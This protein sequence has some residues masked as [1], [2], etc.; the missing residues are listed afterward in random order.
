MNQNTFATEIY[1]AVDSKDIDGILS[2]LTH[3]AHFRFANIPGAKGKDN[4]RD[5]LSA[6]YPT[7]KS[8]KHADLESWFT[9][10]V[11]FING[12]VTY[13]RPDDFSLNVP[14]GVLLRLNGDLIKEWLIFVDNSALYK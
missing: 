13:V 8:I 9:D 3:D 10:G 14:F 7:I 6:F 12:N 2:F 4:I 11:C 1:R 5:F